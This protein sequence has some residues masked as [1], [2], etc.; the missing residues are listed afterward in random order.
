MKILIVLAHPNPESFNHGIAHAVRDDLVAE[1]HEVI[2]RDLYAEGFESHYTIDDSQQD[3]VLPEAVEAYSD[4]VC[5]A[6]GIVIV[7]PNWWC[8]PPAIL[9]GWL[10]RALRPGKAYRFEPSGAVGLLRAKAAVVINTANNPEEQEQALYGDPLDL[11]WRGCV[12]KICG[13]TTVHRGYFAPV[14]LSTP[15]QRAEWIDEAKAM[16]R[17][18]FAAE[19]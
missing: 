9:K 8:Q 2:L 7:H 11:I 6:D 3:A 17:E 5:S 16:C 15:E 19:G 18:A 14:I 13:V 12:F 4:E 1:G 10:D